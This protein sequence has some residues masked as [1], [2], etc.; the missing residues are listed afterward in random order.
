MMEKFCNLLFEL[1][2]EDRLRIFFKLQKN[3]MKLTHLSEKPYLKV[4]ETSR[5]L[6]RLSDAK[7]ISKDVEGF[8]HLTIRIACHKVASR[9]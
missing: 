7:L 3:I 4:Q 8:Y 1:S 6:S 5:H 9:I 2:H